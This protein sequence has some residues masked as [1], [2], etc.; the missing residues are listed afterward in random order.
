MHRIL[1]LPEQGGLG[2]RRCQWHTTTLNIPSQNA[3]LRLG[4]KF[5]GIWRAQKALAPGKVG[6]AREWRNIIPDASSNP[7]AGRKGTYNE[8][9]MVRDNWWAS[10]TFEDWDAG[11]R[12]HIDRLMARRS[13]HVRSDGYD[14]LIVD[15]S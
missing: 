2:L 12:D 14:V 13:V 3:A 11:V 10:V 15:R 8:D 6:R 7:T 4:Y 5:E 9:H 1:D